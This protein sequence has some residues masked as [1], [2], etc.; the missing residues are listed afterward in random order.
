MEQL[1]VVVT[2]C[3]INIADLTL[4]LFILFQAI[5]G[6]RETERKHWK[7]ENKAII[8]RMKDLAFGPEDVILPFVHVLDLEKTGCIKAHVDSV[9]VSVFVKSLFDQLPSGLSIQTKI[10]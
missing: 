8:Q 1:P 2:V 5:H 4:L 6:Y 3:Q 10:S 7:Q 9:R